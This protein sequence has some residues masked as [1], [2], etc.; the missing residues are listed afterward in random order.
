MGFAGL[1]R[2]SDYPYAV[3]AALVPMYALALGGLRHGLP[4]LVTPTADDRPAV[5]RLGAPFEQLAPV[6]PP[7]PVPLYRAVA[8]AVLGGW[9]VYCQIWRVATPRWTPREVFT[10]VAL[11]GVF[12]ALARFTM[13]RGGSGPPLTLAGRW[14]T[15]RWIIRG[16]DAVYFTTLATL[17]VSVATAAALIGAGASAGVAAGLSVGVTLLVAL[18]LPPTMARWQLTAERRIERVASEKFI[19]LA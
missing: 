7:K 14:R 5:K 6:R 15:G 9:A 17:L 12:V 10:I 8:G 19:K 18:V 11:M 16:Y 13:Y 1:L 3:A 2:L 4:K